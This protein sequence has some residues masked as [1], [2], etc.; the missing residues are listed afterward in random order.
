M[1]TRRDR[2]KQTLSSSARSAGGVVS[3]HDREVAGRLRDVLGGQSTRCFTLT[4]GDHLEIDLSDALV[5]ALAKSAEIVARGETVTVLADEQ[6]LTSQEAA[7]LLNVSRQY[8]VRLLD[9][10]DIPAS[11]TGAHRRVRV[12]D[13]Q[14]YRLQRDRAR[15][16]ALDVLVEQAQADGGYDAPMGFGPARA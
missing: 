11:K 2:T 9:R 4:Y 7:D 8:L 13:V 1:H 12:A 14:A 5:L 3:A 10:G 16:E 15:S 6:E